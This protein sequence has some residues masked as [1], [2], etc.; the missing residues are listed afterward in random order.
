MNTD[1][2]NSNE[3]IQET[4]KSIAR[5]IVFSDESPDAKVRQIESAIINTRKEII[6]DIRNAISGVVLID[7]QFIEE[8]L[9]EIGS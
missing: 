4:A 2:F 9:D 3:D 5:E 7:R 1:R 8:L 6:D